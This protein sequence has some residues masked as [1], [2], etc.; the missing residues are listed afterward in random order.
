[1]WE[2]AGARP[3]GYFST[4]IEAALEGH[5]SGLSARATAMA[6]KAYFE[7]KGIEF[8][9]EQGVIKRGEPR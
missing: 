3:A 7:S 6:I 2:G 8:I 5:P 4:A 1:M 9:G